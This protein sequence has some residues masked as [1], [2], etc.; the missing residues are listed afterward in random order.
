[1]S[2]KKNG[3][4]GNKGEWSEMYVFFKLLFDGTLKGSDKNGDPNP[5]VVMD[6]L[7]AIRG[8]VEA[9]KGKLIEVKGPSGT[10]NFKPYTFGG[11]AKKLFSTI[12]KAKGVFEDPSAKQFLQKIGVTQLNAAGP[13]KRDLTVQVRD[14]DRG[15]TPSF[16]F[17]V[18]S[19]IGG[20]P[21]LL[22]A[23]KATNL[24][25]EVVGL[26][27]SDIE[28]INAIN[29]GQKIIKRC[30]IIK[31]R[32]Q[33]INFI[34]FNKSCFHENLQSIDDGLPE[35]ISHFVKAHY[36]EGCSTC[37]EAVRFLEKTNPRGYRT[38]GRYEVKIKRFLRSAALGMKPA[39]IW[40]DSDDATGGYIIA[41]PNG[42]L[43]A[44]YIYDRTLFDDYLFRLTKFERGS[45]TK[46]EF[47]TI[48]SE[49]NRS[50]IKLNL[51]I[52]FTR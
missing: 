10:F 44:F 32:A 6:V 31:E 23:T 16:G 15:C 14:K 8:Q 12:R 20:A 34:S 30:A 25:Y 48:Y 1:M 26:S 9:T 22:N 2:K 7:K 18:K 24:I 27:N 43:V 49:G 36:F 28:E 29:D 39:S 4:K 50:F 51:Q 46:H 40:N 17:S 35:I 33:E 38:P 52:R 47:L 11:H 13:N 21:T 37:E 41:K 19:E 45:I 3:F 5:C 42:E